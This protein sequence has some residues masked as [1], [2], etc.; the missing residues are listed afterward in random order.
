MRL[1]STGSADSVTAPQTLPAQ[2]KSLRSL[3]Q[4]RSDHGLTR[5]GSTHDDHTDATQTT[6]L[7]RTLTD[8]RAASGVAPAPPPTVVKLLPHTTRR[9]TS[10]Q[11]RSSSIVL[12]SP[13]QD[14]TRKPA[15]SA[16]MA[17]FR[18]M[19]SPFVPTPIPVPAVLSEVSGKGKPSR[20]GS[21]GRGELRAPGLLRTPSTP[22]ATPTAIVSP[23]QLV[24]TPDCPSR[25]GRA[26][27]SLLRKPLGAAADRSPVKGA[28]IAASADTEQKNALVPGPPLVASRTSAFS[29]RQRPTRFGRGVVVCEASLV[30][31]STAGGAET[32]SPAPPSNP[33]AQS[34]HGVV[35][36]SKPAF[37]APV[38]RHGVA[39][40]AQPTGECLE[41]P[42]GGGSNVL[43]FSPFTE[44][45]HTEGLPLEDLD[46]FDDPITRWGT[47]P[48]ASPRGPK[49]SPGSSPVAVTLAR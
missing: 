34:R 4:R 27:R 35:G 17:R 21:R 49:L 18:E 26:Q 25:K 15:E 20:H 16:S 1:G 24:A 38:R 41:P 46:E 7:T 29:Q 31:N 11:A 22:R 9:P 23:L 12:A 48:M 33:L 40:A 39:R 13:P 10:P 37:S 43:L 45:P 2:P 30:T 19:R 8:A 6:G 42:S 44:P 36:T 47:S 3:L 28:Q 32:P 14:L 5:R